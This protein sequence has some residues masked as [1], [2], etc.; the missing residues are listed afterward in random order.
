MFNRLSADAPFQCAADVVVETFGRE[1]RRFVQGK[2]QAK[3]GPSRIFEIV[4]LFLKRSGQLR[5]PEHI[6]ERGVHVERAGNELPGANGLPA[7]KLNA[8]RAA[9]FD[10]DL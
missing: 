3:Q 4:E 1:M 8:G 10:D 6:L 9:A 5:T 7:H 2:V